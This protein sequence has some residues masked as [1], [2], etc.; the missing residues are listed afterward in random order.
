MN[1]P[2]PAPV[3][4]DPSDIVLKQH[5]IYKPNL[6]PEELMPQ[7]KKNGL[8]SLSLFSGGGGLD[9]GFMRAGFTHIASY[10]ILK[11]AGETLRLNESEWTV[12]SGPE[13]DVKTVDWTQYKGLVDVVHGGPPCQPFSMA[14]KQRGKD[15]ERDMIPEFV[16]CVLEIEPPAFLMENVFALVSNKFEGYLEDNFY[17]PLS[18]KYDVQLVVLRSDGFGIPQVR[19]RVFFFGF[20]KGGLI[21]KFTPPKPT[22]YDPFISKNEQ[23]EIFEA[24]PIEELR[25][26]MGAREALGLPD[27][28]YDNLIPTMRSALTGAHHTTSVLSSVSAQ[29]KWDL[30]GIWPNGV[31]ANRADA[32]ILPTR[33]GAYRL[34]VQDCALLQGFPDSWKFYGAIYMSLGQIGNSV[35]PVVAYNVAK[36]IAQTLS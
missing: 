25:K 31:A 4:T 34:S 16:R 2:I 26:C 9:L 23:L 7:L 35:V 29:K 5:P 13:G 17:K 32:H 22:H 12:F 10:E 11:D 18:E 33:N 19:K 6:K 24:K 20:K 30:L 3:Q 15:D 28:G 36:A 14:G 1:N 8:R 21:D 27:I